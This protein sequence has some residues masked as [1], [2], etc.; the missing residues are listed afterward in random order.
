MLCYRS[1]P[2]KLIAD[3]VGETRQ[4]LY[5][6]KEQLL[7]KGTTRPMKSTTATPDVTLLKD[8]RYF[9][10]K[11]VYKLRLEKEILE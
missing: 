10:Q 4:L 3:N 1:V 2:A 8:E 6:R 7:G 11:E 9:L 5:L